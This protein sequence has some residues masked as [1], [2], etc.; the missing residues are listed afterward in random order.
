MCLTVKDPDKLKPL[1]LYGKEQYKR[2]TGEAMPEPKFAEKNMVVFKYSR[3][4]DI[5]DESFR[6]FTMD[7]FIYLKYEIQPVV[8]LKPYK[9][10]NILYNES[11]WNIEE[12]YHAYLTVE[13]T[14]QEAPSYY[15]SFSLGVFIIP[16]GSMYYEG[17]NGDIVSSRM[18]YLMPFSVWDKKSE[19]QQKNIISVVNERLKV[20]N[21]RFVKN[22]K[23]I[24]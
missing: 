8:E 14:I 23:I 5:S 10:K 20:K 1:E 3:A 22:I 12:G 24:K 18:A 15:Y 2:Y 11:F 17:I 7:S 21:K 6:S 16:K 9:G 13:K 4:Y 19:E